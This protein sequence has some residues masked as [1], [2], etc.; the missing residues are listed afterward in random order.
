M[1]ISKF[2]GH[3]RICPRNV[4]WNLRRNSVYTNE[5]KMF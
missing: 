1:T 2:Q 5:N 3:T 4:I